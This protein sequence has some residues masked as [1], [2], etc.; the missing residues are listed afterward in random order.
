MREAK[1]LIRRV[2]ML[3]P[4]EVLEHCAE[5]TACAVPPRRARRASAL[6]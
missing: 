2:P 1:A 4:E 3:P 5:T 6:F